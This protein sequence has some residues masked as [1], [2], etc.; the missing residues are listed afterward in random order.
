MALVCPNLIKQS[1]QR[2]IARSYSR[3]L[4]I[5]NIERTLAQFASSCF[6]DTLIAS[7][8]P[9]ILFVSEDVPYVNLASVEMN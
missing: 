8:S 5:V 7:V 3:S 1:V 9:V 6:V 4:R 2:F